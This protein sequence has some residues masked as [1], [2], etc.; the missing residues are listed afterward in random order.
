MT[1]TFDTKTATGV[2]ATEAILQTAP[3]TTSIVNGAADTGTSTG[4]IV[5]SV[6]GSVAG[7]ALIGLVF[8]FFMSRKKKKRLITPTNMVEVGGTTGGAG[9]GIAGDNYLQPSPSAPS[10]SDHHAMALSTTA[11]DSTE[12]SRAGN[13]V[14]GSANSGGFLSR[15]W[16]TA[17]SSAANGGF[18][19]RK[20]HGADPGKPNTGQ[21]RGRTG[22]SIPRTPEPVGPLVEP[23]ENQ[24]S[25]Y[26]A[27]KPRQGSI[28]NSSAVPTNYGGV[29]TTPS[30]A[31]S[32]SSYAQGSTAQR[33]TPTNVF[34]DQFYDRSGSLTETNSSSG[35]SGDANTALLNRSY[36]PANAPS[37]QAG[38]ED[39]TGGLHTQHEED[40]SQWP[41]QP[42]ARHVTNPDNLTA[43]ANHSVGRF[44]D[45]SEEESNRDSMHFNTIPQPSVPTRLYNG[46]YGRVRPT[47]LSAAEAAQQAYYQQALSQDGRQPG[48]YR[49][50]QPEGYRQPPPQNP[51]RHSGRQDSSTSS[52]DEYGD[53]GF[54]RAKQSY[55]T[56]SL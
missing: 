50:H 56:E 2:L 35:G 30:V 5:G 44:S 9:L 14:G 11:N 15:L 41:I 6:V 19:T 55:F 31:A 21:N 24:R 48:D 46:T 22:E 53:T 12:V 3:I 4:T 27:P 28:T 10:I 37:E 42:I 29:S 52:D 36:H 34:N 40:S 33:A 43:Q 20:F 13:S 47:S 49:G 25:F 54:G 38:Y 17:G 1:P 45:V 26:R 23:L 51:T 16:P 18:F 7:V 32:T 39:V 8:L